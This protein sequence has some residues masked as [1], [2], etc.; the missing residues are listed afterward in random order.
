MFK[1]LIAINF[2]LILVSLISGIFFLAKDGDQSTR[3]VV[4]LTL[5]VILS[6]SL[7]IMLIAG[8][9]FGEITPH[10]L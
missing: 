3:V 5:R 7:V 1:T 9:Y 10:G 6:F 4:S 2:I 8:W